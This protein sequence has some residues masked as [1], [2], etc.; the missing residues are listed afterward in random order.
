LRELLSPSETAR[1]SG[2]SWPTGGAFCRLAALDTA[3]RYMRC[4]GASSRILKV[5]PSV[6]VLDPARH[7]GDERAVKSAVEEIDR[8]GVIQRA[9][10]FISS[11]AVIS[12]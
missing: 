4:A 5:P 1:E 11:H 12:G 8:H 2:K 3:L 9:A 10:Q 7:G 6:P